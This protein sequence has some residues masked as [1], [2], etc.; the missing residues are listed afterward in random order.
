MT[1]GQELV[2]SLRKIFRQEG[3]FLPA[4][5]A[6]TPRLKA[7]KSYNPWYNPCQTS[8]CQPLAFQIA[9]RAFHASVFQLEDSNYSGVQQQHSTQWFKTPNKIK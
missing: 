2:H 6:V 8:D 4:E 7:T 1:G 9:C 5:S 3:P